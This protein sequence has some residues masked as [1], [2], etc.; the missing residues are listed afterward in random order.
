M[1]TP[2]RF[3]QPLRVIDRLAVGPEVGAPYPSLRFHCLSK[4]STKIYCAHINFHISSQPLKILLGEQT[5]CSQFHKTDLQ[6]GGGSALG[7]VL[8]GGHN[9]QIMNVHEFAIKFVVGRYRG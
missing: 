2:N 9:A 8:G 7:C 5:F 3:Q 1:H 6:G 4:A